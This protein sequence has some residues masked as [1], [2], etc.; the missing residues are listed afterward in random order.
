MNELGDEPGGLFGGAVADS[1]EGDELGVAQAG[2]QFGGRV[3]RHGAVAVS[4]EDEAGGAEGTTEGAAETGH[5]FVPGAEQAKEMVDG[6]GGAEVIAIGLEA[7]RGVA[8]LGAGHAAETEHLEPL[9][10]PGESVGE[11]AA[12]GGE[13]E[14]DE[15][16]AFVEEGVRGREQDEGTKAV[17]A[18]GCEA[19]GDGSSVGVAEDDG[20]L[21]TD[22]G[23]KP[24]D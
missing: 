12:G 11:D 19:H 15:Q 8:S 4:P 16:V 1:G 2:P 21:E 9:G 24:V 3:E 20:L 13:I 23:E 22:D 18:M 7:G 10:E 17:A 6:S 5:V 14:A